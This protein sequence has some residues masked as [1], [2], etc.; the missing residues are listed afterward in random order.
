MALDVTH[1]LIYDS[2]FVYYN[3]QMNT[4]AQCGDLQKLFNANSLERV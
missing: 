2:L 3:G 4:S 1:Q